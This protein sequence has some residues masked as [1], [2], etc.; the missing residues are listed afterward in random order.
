MVQSIT[1][2]VSYYEAGEDMTNEEYGIYMRAIHKF[3]YLDI[4]P[5][6]STLPPLVKAALRTVIASIRKNKDD[7]VNGSKGGA[8][9]GNQNAKKQ[10]EQKT[11]NNPPCFSENNPPCFSESTNGKGNGKENEKGN[12]NGEIQGVVFSPPQT[13]ELAESIYETLEAA[14]LP[15]CNHNLISFTQSDFKY[16]LEMIHSRQDLA[17]IHSDDILAALKNYV[18]VLENPCTWHGWKG[19]KSFDRFV[20]WERFK[21]FLP[22][23]F[24]LDNFLEHTEKTDTRGVGKEDAMRIMREMGIT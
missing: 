1:E 19:K 13:A 22:D 8:K 2:Y 5:D 7:R 16:G 12:G 23:R 20:S 24:C 4:E 10:P 6:Y 3:A 21:D 9:A 11:E 17:G 15:C 18:K 14:D